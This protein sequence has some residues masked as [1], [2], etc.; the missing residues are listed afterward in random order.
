MSAEVTSAATIIVED[1]YSELIENA[2]GS[3][4]R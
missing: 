2:A 4:V 3:V 1:I